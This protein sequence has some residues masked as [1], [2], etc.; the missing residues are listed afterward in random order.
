MLYTFKRSV[1]WSSF[2]KYTLCTSWP[3]SQLVAAPHVE[4]WLFKKKD[5]HGHLRGHFPDSRDLVAYFLWLND[6][7]EMFFFNFC[8]MTDLKC[9]M[10]KYAY[11]NFGI[12]L[13]CHTTEKSENQPKGSLEGKS[14]PNDGFKY[15]SSFGGLIFPDSMHS[16]DWQW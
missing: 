11:A 4:N 14:L 6:D 2:M 13:P 5:S 1:F 15:S 16:G 12:S 9:N 10:W 7:A 8:I 3:G